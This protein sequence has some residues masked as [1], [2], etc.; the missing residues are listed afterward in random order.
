MNVSIIIVSYNTKDLTRNCLNSIF[1]KTKNI[2]FEVIVSDNGSTD[3][4]IEMIRG[5]FPQVILIENNENLGFG[6]ANNAGAR[7]A[8]GKYLLF[9]NSDTVLL[10][11]AVKEFFDEEEKSDSDLI[12]GAWL[13]SPDGQIVTSYGKFTNPFSYILKKN[14]YDFFPAILNVRL[15]HIYSKRK[16]AVKKLSV[17]FVTGAD[18]FM[19]KSCFQNIGGFDEKIFMY[20]EDEDL[21]RRCAAL[22]IER[23]IVSAPRIVHLEGAS[24]SLKLKKILIQDESFFYY[25]K[26]WEKPVRRFFILCTFWLMYPMRL[27]SKSLSAKEKIQMLKANMKRR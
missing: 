23:R 22:G 9:L 5:E 12:L 15:R 26:K 3:G 16:E 24:S 27:V 8:Q 13:Y 4:S 17:D 1:E 14:V 10:N 7:I 2:S 20:F 25:I 18:L 11:N 19:S 6:R 21:C